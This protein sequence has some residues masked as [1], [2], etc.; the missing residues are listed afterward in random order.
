MGWNVVIALLGAM[1]SICTS[2]TI[3][4]NWLKRQN[5]RKKQSRDFRQ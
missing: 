5:R 1:F 2:E 4:A 3:S